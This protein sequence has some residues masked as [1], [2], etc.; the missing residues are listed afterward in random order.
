M[1]AE[2]SLEV[3]GEL[4]L[5]APAGH[6]PAGLWWRLGTTDTRAVDLVEARYGFV[7]VSWI[8]FRLGPGDLDRQQDGMVAIAAAAL[9]A[10][11]ADAVFHADF[12]EVWLLRIGGRVLLSDDD[13]RWPVRRRAMLP[14]GPVLRRSLDQHP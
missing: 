5:F 2:Y 10:T 11:D 6:Q 8:H 7:P 13:L 1:S 3:A 14:G 9:A 4:P 12:E